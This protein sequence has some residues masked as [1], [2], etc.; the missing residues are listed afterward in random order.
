MSEIVLLY[1]NPLYHQNP[2]QHYSLTE[3]QHQYAQLP[4]EVLPACD[5]Q[6][7]IVMQVDGEV[8]GFFM[9][10]TSA[11][12]K[13][14]IPN[15]RA[16]LITNFS[17]EAHHQGKGYAKQGLQLMKQFVH[18]HFPSYNAIVIAVNNNNEPAQKLYLTHGF[19]DTGNRMT[20]ARGEKIVLQMKVI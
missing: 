8:V 20:N 1:Y 18:Q 4:K 12:I 14:E 13:T 19:K 6:Y 16:L 2:L 5:G 3:E 15:T 10:H 9:I 11:R 7:P 17:I